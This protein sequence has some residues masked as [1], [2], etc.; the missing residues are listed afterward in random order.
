L[1]LDWIIAI[2]IFGFIGAI[3]F[4]AMLQVVG[5]LAFIFAQAQERQIT[6][7]RVSVRVSSYDYDED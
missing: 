4:A 2:I 3:G 1:I 6:E 7:Q 5:M